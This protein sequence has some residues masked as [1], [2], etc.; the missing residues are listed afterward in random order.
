M[1]FLFLATVWFLHVGFRTQGPDNAK[2][3]GAALF[4]ASGGAH[5]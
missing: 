5:G 2:L 1:M 4:A 3:T